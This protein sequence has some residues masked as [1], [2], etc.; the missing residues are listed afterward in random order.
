MTSRV[1][2]PN[3]AY[4]PFATFL[5]LLPGNEIRLHFQQIELLLGFALPDSAKRREWWSNNPSN[6]ALTRAWLSAGFKSDTVDT[7]SSLATFRRVKQ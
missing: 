6:S 4:N 2:A 3:G 5:R 7:A 1:R